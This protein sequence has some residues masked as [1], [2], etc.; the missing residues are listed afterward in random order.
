M[1]SIAE[2]FAQ[3]PVFVPGEA[4]AANDHDAPLPLLRPGGAA[5]LDIGS[6]VEIAHRVADDL[7]ERYGEVV[8][9]EGEFWRFNGTHWQPIDRGSD[10]RL[11][12]H[13]YDG[14]KYPGSDDDRVVRLNK[15]RV[16]STL[17]EMAALLRQA[18]FFAGAETGINCRSG[19][20]RFD[21]QGNPT[22]EPLHRRH[23]ARH[24]LPGAW[25]VSV[26]RARAESSLLALLLG[27]CFLGEDDATQKIALLAELAGAA[28]LGYST[29]LIKPKACIFKGERAENGKSQI[30]D[31]LRGLLPPSAVSSVPPHKFSD[32]KFIVGLMGKMLNASDELTSAAAIGADV[33]KNTVTGEPVSGRDVYR[34]MVVFRPIAL[35]VYATNDL[36]SFRGGMDRCVIRRL[37]VVPFNRT[38]PEHERVERIGQRI[39]TEEANV[40]WRGGNS[41]LKDRAGAGR[42][43]AIA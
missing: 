19:F 2:I 6:D 33:F 21:G 32:E 24:V 15:A 5:R 25:P 7:R 10:L 17:N 43:P 31:L 38:I 12:V 37:M 35:H 8:F 11:A 9:D 4:M 18:D 13:L 41:P 22:L 42:S 29:R 40:R 14:A 27:G 23:R 34:S 20:I 36:P 30:L 39:A 26:D 3:A 1:T 16:D 28:A